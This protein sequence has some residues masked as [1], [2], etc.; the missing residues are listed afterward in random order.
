MPL[1][2]RAALAAL[3]PLSA[4]AAPEAD[5]LTL[6]EATPD[7]RSLIVARN[8]T[9]LLE[10][11]WRGAALQRP[12]NIKSASKTIVAT[13]A[14]IAAARGVFSLDDRIA[15]MLGR[16]VP[17][18]ADPRVGQITVRQ[19]MG[20]RAGLES[21]SGAHYGRWV[22]SRNWLGFALTRPFVDEPGG[23]MIYSTGS[24]HILGVVLARA[25][26][27]SLR[28]LAQAWLGTPLGFTVP[29]WRRDP[30]GHYF[31]GNDMALSPQALLAF[32]ECCRNQGR[33]RDREVV[34]ATFLAEATIPRARSAFSGQLYGLGWWVSEA[35]GEPMTFAWGYGGQMVYILPR[36][37]MTVVMTSDADVPR[38]PGQVFTRHALLADGILPAFAAG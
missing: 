36:L 1:T 15:P 16:L 19:L 31:G 6:A 38:V 10:R 13:L 22:S 26:G 34:P 18:E 25:T 17:A 24:S 9:P 33:Y 37:N 11:T 14:G 5:L 4:Q 21:T 2:R 27:R 29:E 7:L 30:Q 20:M 35:R 3:V 32:G 8:G 12:T 23:G 28:E